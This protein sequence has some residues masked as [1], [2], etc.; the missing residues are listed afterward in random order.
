MGMPEGQYEPYVSII[1]PVKNSADT[2]GELMESLMRLEYT[3]EKLEIIVVDGR[4]TDGTRE[5]VKR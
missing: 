4:S 2:I 1:V 5:N 3:R